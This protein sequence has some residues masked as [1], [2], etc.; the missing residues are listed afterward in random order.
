METISAYDINM[1]P[2]EKS[3]FD[4][5]NWKAKTTEAYI[6]EAEIFLH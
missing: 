6:P 1:T 5:C 4:K 2:L 3:H